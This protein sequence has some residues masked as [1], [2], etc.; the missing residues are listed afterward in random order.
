MAQ[1]TGKPEGMAAPEG[2]E[3]G[4]A[5]VG[6]RAGSAAGNAAWEKVVGAA[7]G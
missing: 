4:T 6:G 7:V 1:G 5:A 3:R 2:T